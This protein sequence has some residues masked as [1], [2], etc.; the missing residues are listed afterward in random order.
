ML[1]EAK[2][3]FECFKGN[4]LYFSDDLVLATPKRARELVDGLRKFG[5]PLEY[6]VSA[7]FDILNRLDDNLLADMKETGCRIM[8]LGIESG[9]DR[10]L[11]IIGKNCTST[12]ILH[13]L[14][15]LKQV[16]ILPTVSIMV[17][18]FD[19]TKDDVEASIRLMLESVRDNPNIQYAFTI[20]T[21]FPGSPLYQHIMKNG[22]L[23]GDEEFF[24][25]YFS[26]HSG[27]NMVV[28]LSRMSDEEVWNMYNKITVLYCKEQKK[29]MSQSVKVISIIRKVWRRF[30]QL[31]ESRFIPWLFKQ[32]KFGIALKV[33]RLIQDTISYWL[34]NIELKLRGI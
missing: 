15:R 4:M 22:L 11:K 21:P 29:V 20:T 31:V 33:Y 17:G 25:K 24:K 28:N 14:R 32:G 3:A 2:K 16:G 30:N 10:I 12:Q 5:R 6:S 9:S 8:G 1:T 13:N 18:Q 7:R 27:W 34:E 23:R 26:G 19:E